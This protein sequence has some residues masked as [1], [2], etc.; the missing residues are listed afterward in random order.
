MPTNSIEVILKKEGPMLSSELA[1]HL[2]AL[3]LSPTAARKRVERGC[4]GMTRL[5]HILFPHRARF[6]Y[7]QADYGSSKFFDKLHDA[8]KKTNSTYYHALM[9]LEM[10]HHLMPRS[11]F[12]VACGAPIAQKG[13]VSAENLTQRL[14]KA[15]LIKEVSIAGMEPLIVRTDE[16]TAVVSGLLLA[17][18][19]GRLLAEQIALFA[20][21]DWARNLGLV[22]YN[23][24]ATREDPER[25]TLPRV[26]SF[27][28]DLSGPTYLYPMRTQG[29]DKVLPGFLVCD[30]ALTGEV[31]AEEMSAFVKKCVTI[32]SLPKVGRCLQIFVAESYTKEALALLKGEGIIPA[33]P[34][35]LFGRD[36]AKAL[37]QVCD[38]LINTAKLVENPEALDKIFKDL[39]RIEGAASTLRGSL[40]EFAVAQIAKW[41]F[42]GYEAELNR[43]VRDAIGAS[44]EIDLLVTRRNSEVISIE[45]KG[46]HPLA[47]V[48]DEEV[49][50]W[51]DQRIPVIRGYLKTNSE[52]SK[53]PQRYEMWT[54]GK[55]SEAA[56]AMVQQRQA[57][58]QKYQIFLRD[59]EYVLAQAKE[60]NEQGLIKTYTQHFITHPMKEFEEMK[61]REER[62]AKKAAEHKAKMLASQLL[63]NAGTPEAIPLSTQQV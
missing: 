7:L 6:V 23:A 41:T 9:A 28:W 58:S 10:R 35:S 12:L 26:S 25:T 43:I 49:R 61:K 39:S 30:I 31:T 22:S 1:K 50:K 37:K 44:A 40:F 36:V 47:F 34:E 60:T 59:S 2:E 57:Q 13:H 15:T 46:M 52:L 42:P 17:E 29:P 48:D 27:H 55:Y 51:L 11:H 8:L 24:V 19:R 53:L 54:S 62:N 14:I 16:E 33:S 38:I 21:R 5:N 45:C 3:G 56:I 63:S 4:E 18:M 20:V 32:R